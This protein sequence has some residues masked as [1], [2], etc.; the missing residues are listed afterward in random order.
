MAKKTNTLRVYMLLSICFLAMPFVL[1]LLLRGP[2]CSGKVF[3][4]ARQY[5]E[6]FFPPA[7]L[8]HPVLDEKINIAAID[9]PYTFKF[10][11]KYIGRYSV[12]IALYGPDDQL[13]GTEYD[14]LKLRIKINLYKNK[15]LLLSVPPTDKYDKTWISGRGKGVT[16]GQFVSPEEVPIDTDITC[17]VVVLAT[18]TY[19]AREPS[20]L[21]SRQ[22]EE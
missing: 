6:M 13:Y 14:Y 17:E 12:D 2:I 20:I 11:L 1:L 21:I 5:V 9:R 4:S 8:Y 10:K 3:S 18:D 19:L 7:D 15:V 22:S 16:V